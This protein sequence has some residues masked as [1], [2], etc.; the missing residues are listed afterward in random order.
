MK[1]SILNFFNCKF[2]KTTIYFIFVIALLASAFGSL[3]ARERVNRSQL[4]LKELS[5]LSSATGWMLSPA[6]EWESK[7]NR[8]PW[9]LDEKSSILKKVPE[10]ALGTDNFKNYK[11]YRAEEGNQ[12]FI[13]F[14]KTYKD[15]SYL[16]ENIK[17]DWVDGVFT[18]A[19]AFELDELKKLQNL[20]D[21]KINKIEINAFDYEYI[22]FSDERKAI[23]VIKKNI[24]YQAPDRF[25][26]TLI[27]EIFPEKSKKLTQ[28]NIYNK[29]SN[30]VRDNPYIN[31]TSIFGSNELFKH[32]YYEL[33]YD[34]FSSFLTEALKALKLGK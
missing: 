11:F 9:H 15:G 30:G 32:C 18:Q 33:P 10:Y 26:N 4:E 7:K 23:D 14:V 19:Y 2:H 6:G 17:E 22:R 29:S 20:V 27:F 12:I 13:V 5:V 31:G 34:K 3:E 16:Y 28:F 21:E 1:R 24:G 25:T 8:I